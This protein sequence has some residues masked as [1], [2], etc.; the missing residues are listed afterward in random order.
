MQRL[1]PLLL[2]LL[3]AAPAASAPLDN[4]VARIA[5]KGAAGQALWG[6]Y[7]VDLKSGKELASYNANKLF[8]PASN[9]KLVT[10]ALATRAFRADEK[11]QT[12]L[13]AE[14]ITG[15][16]ARGVVL[17]AAG[18]PSWTP[19]LSGG[20]PGR[21][22]LKRLAKSAR[23]AG[24]SR[25]DGDLVIDT[26]VYSEHSPLPPGWPW[27]EFA[28]SYAS[29]PS[30]LAVD[31][32]LAGVQIKP[33]GQGEP[34]QVSFM[35]GVEPFRVSNNA[36]TNRAG[37]APT[38][39]LSMSPGGDTMILDGTIPADA[40][41]ASRSVPMGAPAEIA[42]RMFEHALR[43]E[44]IEFPGTV[45]ITSSRRERGPKVL[46]A[47]EGSPISEMLTLCMEE[48]D[49]YLA[50]SLYLLSSAR[51]AGRGSYTA[52]HDVERAYW[53]ALGV[54]PGDAEPADGSG[55]SR[56]NL[57]TPRAL[58]ALLRERS[59][60]DWFVDALPVSGRTGTMRYRLSEGG[61]AGKVV[62]KTGTLDSVGSL[63]GYV[64]ASSGRTIA[65]SIM[66]NHH[67]CSSAA[68]RA[69]IND[70]VELLAKQ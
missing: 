52:A 7:V 41:P 27:D 19:S 46:A 60:C 8:I 35:G 9:R 33:G 20:R 59:T 51:Q 22:I 40:Q 14:S 64:R 17:H 58:V 66:A 6:V 61:L 4:E 70:I 18:D 39:R 34:P 11:L 49:N 5:S 16:T 37:S 50:E 38:L 53:K 28:N 48:S 55:L 30:A 1:L 29:R 12:T 25:I 57:V 26:S 31:M 24:V 63:S 45:V 13:T 3:I 10:A 42:A 62:A 32:N 15:G 69:S 21:A 43:D 56:K 47:A 23:E 67:T 65:F 54:A 44:G 68:V 36:A 2:L